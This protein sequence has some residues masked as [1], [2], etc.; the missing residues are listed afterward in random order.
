MN[1]EY[2]I[3]E[4]LTHYTTHKVFFRGEKFSTLTN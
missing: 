2:V 1:D 3:N 4:N